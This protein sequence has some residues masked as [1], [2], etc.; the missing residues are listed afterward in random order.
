[1]FWKKDD[2]QSDTTEYN[3]KNFDQEALEEKAN[4]FTSNCLF[5]TYIIMLVVWL[6]N[7]LN[8]FI[9]DHALMNKGFIIVSIFIIIL[10]V[11]R[12]VF[13]CKKPWFKYVLI[14]F[15][16]II[17]TV[18]GITLTYQV[19]ITS[20]FP[21]VYA[22]QYYN[23]RLVYVTYALSCLS[24]FAS[25]MIG[26]YYGLCDANMVVLT[27]KPISEY[28]DFA[29][30][31]VTFGPLNDNPWVTLPLFYVF[32][33]CLLLFPLIPVLTHVS[34]GLAK[35]ELRELYLRRMSEI[36]DMTQFY[37][38]NKYTSMIKE[39]YPKMRKIGVIFWDVNGLKKT[40]DTL[41]HVEGD[42]LISAIAD[43]IREFSS[44]TRKVYRVGGDEFVM[45][46]EKGNEK[47]LE[48]I[49][50]NWRAKV[51]E[52]NKTA[53]VPL[54]SAVG[55][56]CGDGAN[57]NDVINEADENMYNNK[58]AMKMQRDVE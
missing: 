13:G 28:V 49:V 17:M 55:Y 15:C 24:V 8:I 22:M 47:K 45:I 44:D 37:N 12:Q 36:D 32:P 58:V 2:K 30:N 34:E 1:M 42:K 57:L 23:K 52:I 10:F 19:V 18:L 29:T 35:R 56:A 39:E 50:N 6:L 3:V 48:E 41:G 43:S 14:L 7:I 33:R 31:I 25:V 26:Y 40:N 16:V 11:L 53:K 51:E 38:R 54:S 9:V 21:L 46:V 4:I 27:T 20:V 5:V